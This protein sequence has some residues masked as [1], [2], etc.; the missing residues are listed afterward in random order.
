MGRTYNLVYN[1]SYTIAILYYI[2]IY[3]YVFILLKW[4]MKCIDISLMRFSDIM[5]DVSQEKR[6]QILCMLSKV[7]SLCVCEITNDLWISQNLV[8]HHLK[9]LRDLWLVRTAKVWKNI[10]YAVNAE[11]FDEFKERI[12]YIFNI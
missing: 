7:E 8:S 3:W 6:L 10:H 1:L 4:D 2:N 11:K 9:I 12:K 5:K